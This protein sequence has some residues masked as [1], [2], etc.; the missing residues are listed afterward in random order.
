MPGVNGDI[1]FKID[2]GADVTVVDETN[3][4]KLGLRKSHIK[5]TEKTLLGPGNA[6]GMSKPFSLWAISQ[7]FK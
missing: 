5:H 1:H 6:W 7:M 4:Q 2:T 3:L